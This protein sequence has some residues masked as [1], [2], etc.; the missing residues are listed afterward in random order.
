[1]VG[2]VEADADEL[3]HA[4]DAGADPG[5]AIDCRERCGVDRAQPVEARGRQ[6]LPGDVVELLRQVAQPTAGIDHAG[7]FPAGGAEAN[8]FHVCLLS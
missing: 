4:A 2:V 3:A 5:F 1:M 7:A 8:Q 6:R